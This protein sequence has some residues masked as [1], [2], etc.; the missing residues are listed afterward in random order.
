M[1]K[2]SKTYIQPN[3]FNSKLVYYDEYGKVKQMPRKS[4]SKSQIQGLPNFTFVVLDET[5]KI[6]C[7]EWISSNENGVSD[8]IVELIELGGKLSV[9]YSAGKGVVYSSYTT[10]V[11]HPTNPNECYSIAH[12][13]TEKSMLAIYWIVNFLIEDGKIPAS[14]GQDDW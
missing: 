1:A 9:K 8:L 3:F 5:Q 10:P 12:R 6:E 2:K 13:D 14:K 4:K 7:N 11:D